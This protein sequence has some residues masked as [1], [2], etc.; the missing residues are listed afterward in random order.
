MTAGP[1]AAAVKIAQKKV[2][3]SMKLP[4]PFF[5]EREAVPDVI[6]KNARGNTRKIP[7]LRTTFERMVMQ[8]MNA[9][10]FLRVS[11]KASPIAAAAR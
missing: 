7:R 5:L 4:C 10:L 8:D 9:A 11:S 3:R 1:V 6:E 2:E